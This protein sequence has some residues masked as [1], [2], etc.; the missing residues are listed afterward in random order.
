ME[1]KLEE[2]FAEELAAP[3][4]SWL[5][6]IALM[7]TLLQG[8]CFNSS[9]DLRVFANLGRDNYGTIS[10]DNLVEYFFGE[11]Y[12]RVREDAHEINKKYAQKDHIKKD[13]FSV[14]IS[15][16]LSFSTFISERIE[17]EN[18][19]SH[20][21][22]IR[23][24]IEE[25]INDEYID[26]SYERSAWWDTYAEDL[27]EDY[28]SDNG[29][30]DIDEAIAEGGL[31]LYDWK[32]DNEYDYLEDWY[33][34]TEYE[35]VRDR[36]I[37]AR[38]DSVD[39]SDGSTGGMV[40]SHYTRI[41]SELFYGVVDLHFDNNTSLN[42]YFEQFEERMEPKVILKSASGEWEEI[43]WSEL[44]SGDEFGFS[45][46][47]FCVVG[48]KF[49]FGEL[50]N[51]CSFNFGLSGR[52]RWY[53]EYDGS[54]ILEDVLRAIDSYTEQLKS[55]LE[56]PSKVYHDILSEEAKRLPLKISS[57]F[58]LNR[59]LQKSFEESSREADTIDSFAAYFKDSFALKY[60]VLDH[61]TAK[62]S[63]RHKLDK[64]LDFQLPLTVGEYP[65]YG[66]IQHSTKL[67]P[68][69]FSI[70]SQVQQDLRVIV[71]NPK[72]EFSGIIVAENRGHSLTLNLNYTCPTKK[73]VSFTHILEEQAVWDHPV[74][75]KVDADVVKFGD[76]H[77]F[78]L[79]VN[80]VDFRDKYKAVFFKPIYQE[81]EPF[82]SSRVACTWE[83][84]T[85]EGGRLMNRLLRYG[86]IPK[87]HFLVNDNLKLG[88]YIVDL[89]PTAHTIALKKCGVT[90]GEGVFLGKHDYLFLGDLFSS[91]R[92]LEEKII[93]LPESAVQIGIDENNAVDNSMKSLQHEFETYGGKVQ[94]SNVFGLIGP[95]SWVVN[96]KTKRVE[97]RFQKNTNFIAQSLLFLWLT[98]TFT[99]FGEHGINIEPLLSAPLGTV[100]ESISAIDGISPYDFMKNITSPAGAEEFPVG[101]NPFSM[102]IPSEDPS[103]FLRESLMR[104]IYS[105]CD[106]YTKPLAILHN[107]LIIDK[108]M[109]EH[110]SNP[111][112]KD[113]FGIASNIRIRGADENWLPTYRKALSASQKD[114]SWSLL[115]K[116]ENPQI[117]DLE[118]EIDLWEEHAR[119]FEWEEFI[120][121]PATLVREE[122][123]PPEFYAEWDFYFELIFSGTLKKTTQE[124]YKKPASTQFFDRFDV[125]KNNTFSHQI[126]SALAF[127]TRFWTFE[128]NTMLV[129]KGFIDSDFYH[130]YIKGGTSGVL[131]VLDLAYLLKYP[132]WGNAL[133]KL[134]Q[135]KRVKVA[136]GEKKPVSVAN[137]KKNIMAYVCI[138]DA[139]APDT[140][141]RSELG[142]FPNE[143]EDKATQQERLSLLAFHRIFAV[144]KT[145][146]RVYVKH[147]T[148]NLEGTFGPIT[149]ENN[150][151]VAIQTTGFKPDR[152]KQLLGVK[153]I[154][155]NNR[156]KDI[157]KSRFSPLTTVY[158]L[159]I[160]EEEY[161]YL[162]SAMRTERTQ[163][164]NFFNKE[165]EA[166]QNLTACVTY[167]KGGLIE[168]KAYSNRILGA[169]SDNTPFLEARNAHF[170]LNSILYMS[171]LNRE[172]YSANFREVSD[173]RSPAKKWFGSF[174]LWCASQGVTKAT[175]AES[176][177]LADKLQKAIATLSREIPYDALQDWQ[178]KKAIQD[179]CPEFNDVLDCDTFHIRNGEVYEGTSEDFKEG[180]PLMD[181]RDLAEALITQFVENPN[182]SWDKKLASLDGVAG[183]KPL[184]PEMLP[185]LFL[186]YLWEQINSQ[187]EEF[188]IGFIRNQTTTKFMTREQYKALLELESIGGDVDNAG[189]YFNMGMLQY[190][191]KK[192]Y[193]P[194]GA[195][196]SV[197]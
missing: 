138:R 185:P 121:L 77:R 103:Y 81:S 115:M 189:K 155:P 3:I 110:R 148:A 54:P 190:A 92:Y 48:F 116:K 166:A 40:L 143:Q 131:H 87:L 197:D 21:S 90:I 47:E 7:S 94:F 175:H 192:E 93:H 154:Y 5:A 141:T 38:V 145:A 1:E 182:I 173:L 95:K 181:I 114:T 41:L 134:A 161:G 12:L 132:T 120:N 172:I 28:L 11:S 164:V 50:K 187:P 37:D 122:D 180:Q 104:F 102:D 186:P 62:V 96:E 99:R 17:A 113:A 108:S 70:T 146:H 156:A 18:W 178:L 80:D 168:A 26:D 179:L 49:P 88:T 191:P 65:R 129:D 19:E 106:F 51:V 52:C 43:V 79:F 83:F 85:S 163:V 55:S 20:A 60:G 151:L 101:F 194:V 176:I 57:S 14:W 184:S 66:N 171:S 58:D 177:G 2:A 9:Q 53:G 59:F 84:A 67:F 139:L 44:Y 126:N 39:F 133:N 91:Q 98:P 118:K 42:N 6:E 72:E 45:G 144:M 69:S 162:K 183:K 149:L 147:D 130:A 105:F 193:I 117:A 188:Y 140:R 78:Y 169:S 25:D 8:Q 22:A 64:G 128:I 13:K 165:A 34:T 71:K 33:S 150:D 73:V 15:Q 32:S 86:G 63:F 137:L 123:I 24:E 109:N 10:T 195:D 196:G 100:M 153:N 127:I 159:C 111:L 158:H 76:E 136:E 75:V 61:N 119:V 31:S 97:V 112:L 152:G 125:Q 170:V 29:W 46:E 174:G 36:G 74:I 27:Y 16:S 35:E 82:V 30:D 142:S 107:F 157:M 124:N 56:R 23:E 4:E 68:T 89:R 135:N 160:A 167:Q